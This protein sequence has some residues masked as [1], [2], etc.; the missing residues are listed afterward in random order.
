MAGP[1]GPVPPMSRA[2]P[3]IACNEGYDR[4]TSY[5]WCRS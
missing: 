1:V 5:V 2:E 4:E 3:V